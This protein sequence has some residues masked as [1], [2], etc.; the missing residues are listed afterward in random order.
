MLSSKKLWTAKSCHSKKL[1]S[2]KLD[3]VWTPPAPAKSW[4]DQWPVF[5]FPSKL[6]LLKRSRQS[7]T[8]CL[9]FAP[10]FLFAVD[11]KKLDELW[12]TAKYCGSRNE[13]LANWRAGQQ[14]N[15]KS[16]NASYM[17]L[18]ETW[19]MHM[20]RKNAPIYNGIF[21]SFI[22]RHYLWRVFVYK[23]SVSL[24][25]ACNHRFHSLLILCINNVWYFHFLYFSY[26]WHWN[27]LRNKASN[28]LWKYY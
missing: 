17:R 5:L 14:K 26:W 22:W 24:T 23:Y 27:V 12:M 3:E 11:S 16:V 20:E 6:L 13:T 1:S 28:K 15:V 8:D 18:Y 25:G 4:P 21:T 7:E 2:K 19:N 9:S 10:F